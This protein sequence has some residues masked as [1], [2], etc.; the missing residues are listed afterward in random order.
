MNSNDGSVDASIQSIGSF[1]IEVPF[2]F[3]T[4]S[5]KANDLPVC[6]PRCC[7]KPVLHGKPEALGCVL[8]MT[9]QAVGL[10]GVGTFVLP[11]LL[12]F[13]KLE[14]GC[15][16]EI[17]E[18]EVEIPECSETVY[19]LKPS[20]LITTMATILSLAVLLMT[21]W[22]VM[23]TESIDISLSDVSFLRLTNPVFMLRCHFVQGGRN[24]R[25]YAPAAAYRKNCSCPLLLSFCPT[26]FS[27]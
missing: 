15:E 26:I 20:S 19:G 10:F 3:E 17:P 18:G 9:G 5:D 12:H 13:A 27:L 1:E 8:G 16:M 25:L 2:D 22:Y 24:C 6:F 23:S 14:A 11:A 4:P 21:P 7:G